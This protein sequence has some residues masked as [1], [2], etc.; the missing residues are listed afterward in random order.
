MSALVFTRNDR[1]TIGVEL[2]LQLIDAESLALTN[3]IEDVLAALPEELR[4]VVKPELMQSYIEINTG[5]CNTVADASNDLRGK[6]EAIE[7]VLDGMGIK[8]LWAATHPFSSWRDQ[9]V[10]N[11]E[12]YFRLVDLMQDVARRLVT[13]GLHVHVGVDTGD[14]AINVC[15]RML[16]YLPLLLALSSNSP[17]WEDRNTGLHSNRSKIME[18]LPTAGLPHVMRN[19]SEYVWIVNHLIETGFMNSIREIWWDIRPHHN[20]GTVEVRVCDMPANLK[21]V[22]GITALVQCLVVAISEEVEQGTYQLDY[23]PMMVQ[24]NKWRATRFGADARLVLSQTYEQTSLAE[25]VANL[26]TRLEAHAVKLGCLD[27]LRSVVNIPAATGAKQQLAIFEQ[28]ASK[29]EVVRQMI[30]NNHW[31]RLQT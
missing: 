8:L 1:P 26:V 13:F 9:K 15:D 24:Q 20:F 27:E 21:Q 11:N 6:L 25:T 18:G 10:T 3:R 28:T 29:Q 30:E 4:D 2:E 19:W 14:K 22:E 16:R 17:F 12:R 31:S 7:N 5:V 23:H